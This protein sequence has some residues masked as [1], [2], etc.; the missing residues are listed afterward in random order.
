MNRATRWIPFLALVTSVVAAVSCQPRQRS[1]QSDA[2]LKAHADSLA[3]SIKTAATLMRGQQWYLAYCAMCHGDAG[4]GDGDMAAGIKARAGV[5]VARLN[6]PETMTRMS[7]V[8]IKQ[9]IS[10]GGGHTGRS[11]IMP[12]W[13]ERLDPATIDDIAAYVASLSGTTPAI[14]RVT[15]EHYLAAPPGVPADGRVLFVHHCT[16][17]HGPYGKGDGPFGERLWETRQVRPRNLTDSTY[18]VTRT[19]KDLFAI[20]SLGAGHFRKSAMMPSWDVTLTP[21]QIKSIVAYIRE[22]SNTPSRP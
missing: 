13:G 21:A 17:C 8:Q 11:N 5:T 15:L 3:D 10:R 22:I 4:N 7:A 20:I 9:V 16:A 6:D 12:A 18:F 14:P 1:A 19:D 2:A